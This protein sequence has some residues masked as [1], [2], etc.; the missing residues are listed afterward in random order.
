VIVC[1][2]IASL[3]HAATPLGATPDSLGTTFR[4]WAPHV[5][6]VAVQIDDHDPVELAREPGH[7]DPEDTTWTAFVPGA[8]AGDYYR[9]LI[10]ASGV[11]NEF[12]D[13]RAWEL[14]SPFPD[15]WSVIVNPGSDV[16]AFDPPALNQLVIYEMHVGSFHADDSTGKFT[17]AGAAQKLDYLKSL[18]VNAVQLM[19][20]N[21]NQQNRGHVPP[22]FD[23]G[24]DPLQYFSVKNAYG[25]PGDLK[26]FVEQCHAR[27]IAAILD[28]VYNHVTSRN[29]L[30]QWGGY[31]PPAFPDGVYFYGGS[32][33]R[34]PWGPRPDFSRPQVRDYVGDNVRL[35]LTHFGF[36]GLRWDSVSNIR[37]FERRGSSDSANPDGIKLLRKSNAEFP[38]KIM[39]AEDLRSDPEVTQPISLGGLGFNSQWDN[40]LCGTLRKIV[41]APT[42]NDRDLSTLADQIQRKIGDDAF[43]RVIYSE[44]H[45]QVGHPQDR[46]GDAP[47]V[48]IPAVVDPR[49]PQSWLAWR[50][51]TLAGAIIMT[52]PGVP[53]IFQGQETFD[54]RTFDFFR[55]PEVD[56]NRVQTFAGALHLYHDLILLRRNVAGKTAGLLGQNCHV[57]HIDGRHVLAFHRWDH[58]GA[59]DDVMVVV[60]LSRL[61]L[62]DVNIGFPAAGKWIV[63]FDSGST[64]YDTSSTTAVGSIAITTNAPADGMN[65]SAPLAIGSYCVLILSQD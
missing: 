61:P 19:P 29:A 52:S 24:Y 33:G 25:S 51:S 62:T 65:F 54:P 10:R 31:A 55:A 45:D 63:R 9:Y 37:G 30:E 59:R 4:V 39:I 15:A 6:D 11:V 3:A 32:A 18:G 64:T 58:G 57:T 22:D 26:N 14:T 12:N 5:D 46:S 20:I 16:A 56:W 60:N 43:G 48:R 42:D 8:K 47:Q 21:E 44:D 1:L 27:G 7:A 13:P 53:M 49:S 41:S 34:S 35:W 28:V 38:R 23:W 40:D 36:D 50:L 2:F 17:F